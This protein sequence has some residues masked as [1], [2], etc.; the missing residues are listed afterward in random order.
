LGDRKNGSRVVKGRYEIDAGPNMLRE[1]RD[2]RFRDADLKIAK[3]WEIFFW[4]I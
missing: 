4:M 3:G 2:D 1:V